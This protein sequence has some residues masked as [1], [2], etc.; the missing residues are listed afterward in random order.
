MTQDEEIEAIQKCENGGEEAVEFLITDYSKDV[1]SVVEDVSSAGESNSDS[2]FSVQS[3]EE[4]ESVN[5]EGSSSTYKKSS[6]TSL[7]NRRKNN[8]VFDVQ[9]VNVLSGSKL[10]NKIS[11][12]TNSLVSSVESSKRS[13]IDANTVLKTMKSAIKKQKNNQTINLTNDKQVNAMTNYYNSKEKALVATETIE[14]K[15]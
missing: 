9:E 12:S 1:T 13:A 7:M 8:A 11:A 3:E 4:D 10:D 15:N 6:K 5:S 2:S 14:E